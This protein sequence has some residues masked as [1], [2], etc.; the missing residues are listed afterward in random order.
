MF[1]HVAKSIWL[2][3]CIN[4]LNFYSF[5]HSFFKNCQNQSLVVILSRSVLLLMFLKFALQPLQR[6]YKK[7]LPHQKRRVH[8]LTATVV[9]LL[10][11]VQTD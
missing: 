1:K 8:L 7:V 9:I 3:E 6:P 10:K 11:P 2:L 5:V 4:R